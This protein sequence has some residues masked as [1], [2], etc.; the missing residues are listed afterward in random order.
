MKF[1]TI[2]K[3]T[4]I[5]RNKPKAQGV[6]DRTGFLV[7]HYDL[8]PQYQYAGSGKVNTGFLI[9]KDFIDKLN[10]QQLAPRPYLDPIPVPNPRTDDPALTNAPLSLSV[11]TSIGSERIITDSELEY[12]EISFVGEKSNDFTVIVPALFKSFIFANESTGLFNL[13]VKMSNLSSSLTLLKENTITYVTCTGLGLLVTNTV[14]IL[15]D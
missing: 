14:E 13:Y 7:M 11:D 10:P 8:K 9:H 12:T 1:R 15:N 5:N 3:Y 4:K 2:G 6:C